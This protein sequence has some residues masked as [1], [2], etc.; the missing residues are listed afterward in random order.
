MALIK[1]K[2]C[3]KEISTDAK[4]CPSCGKKK[5]SRATMIVLSIFIV[6]V[7]IA[8]FSGVINTYTEEKAHMAERERLALLT[9]EQRK[10]E[11]DKKRIEA[12][13]QDEIKNK[14]YARFACQEFIKKGLKNPNDVEFLDSY[15]AK[16]I[17][18]TVYR[19]DLDVRARNSFNALILSNF[20]CSVGHTKDG[21]WVLLSLK[22]NP[23]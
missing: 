5:T 3:G 11:D 6:G 15:T 7:V 4:S 19:I 8:I 20:N 23:R 12:Q 13:K 10:A 18:P 22:E 17:S 2:E 21:N 14:E 1:C 16:Q 9:P